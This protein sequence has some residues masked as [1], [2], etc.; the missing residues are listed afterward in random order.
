MT[1]LS[2][3]L[4]SQYPYLKKLERKGWEFYQEDWVDGHK[5]TDETSYYFSIPQSRS[6]DD[7]MAFWP[8][9]GEEDL[10]QR[11]KASLRTLIEEIARE[12]VEELLRGCSGDLVEEHSKIDLKKIKVTLSIQHK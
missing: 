9:N 4:Y 5:G 10:L 11:G 12:K 2:K 8:D 6:S 1:Q 7:W 3:E